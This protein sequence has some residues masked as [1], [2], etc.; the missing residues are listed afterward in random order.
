M[1]YKL[2]ESY[3]VESENRKF[4]Y[5][6]NGSCGEVRSMLYLAKELKYITQEEFDFLYNQS[7]EISK[8]LSGLIKSL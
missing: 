6:S 2:V 3:K 5:I 8:I 7:V 4:L 1:V